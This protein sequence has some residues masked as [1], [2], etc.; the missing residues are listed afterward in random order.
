MYHHWRGS[1]KSPLADMLID[2]IL[3]AL[4]K[5]DSKSLVPSI[6]CEAIDLLSLSPLSF[7]LPA[8]VAQESNIR[9]KELQLNVQSTSKEISTLQS[10]IRD[11]SSTLTTQVSHLSELRDSINSQLSSITSYSKLNDKLSSSMLTLSTEMTT[12][13]EQ[14]SSSK[15]SRTPN[16]VPLSSSR[17]QLDRVDRSANVVSLAFLNSL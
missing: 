1:E 4:D 6:F 7:D 12:L 2:D 16:S 15:K 17:P 11:I 13:R 5:L 14:I 9:I 10:N 8:A 3:T